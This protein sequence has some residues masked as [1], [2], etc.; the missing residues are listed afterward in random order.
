MLATAA[1][2]H[3]RKTD[4]TGAACSASCLLAQ[5]RVDGGYQRTAGLDRLAQLDAD[6]SA[7][8]LGLFGREDERGVPAVDLG[9]DADAAG[10]ERGLGI[11]LAIDQQVAID[12]GSARAGDVDQERR[13]IGALDRKSV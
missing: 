5:N 1:R 13:T 7:Q 10:D 11:A 8:S 3:L 6:R 2:R 9:I 4:M 12:R